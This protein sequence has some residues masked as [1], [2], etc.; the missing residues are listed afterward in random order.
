MSY[1][2]PKTEGGVEFCVIEP[3]D[4]QEDIVYSKPYVICYVM[5]ANPPYSIVAG[6]LQRVWKAFAIDKILQ[7][8]KGV[9]LV[10]LKREGSLGSGEECRTTL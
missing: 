3:S 1:V 2:A 4:V 10:R 9:L 7:M 5:R 6:F 8:N